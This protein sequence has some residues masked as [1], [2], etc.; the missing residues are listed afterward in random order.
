ML[1]RAAVI[2]HPVAH[3][4]SPVIHRKA[5]AELG[6]DWSYDAID[7]APGGV[8]DFVPGLDASWVGLSVTMPHKV[9]IARH[10]TP[11][12]LVTLTGVA[13]TWVPGV[14]GAI[15]RN[16]DVPG[17]VEACRVH[18]VPAPRR[19]AVVGNGATAR[20]AV[21]A[22]SRL[23]AREVVVLGRDAGRASSLGPLAEALG[24]GFRAHT[25]GSDPITVD[26]LVSTV[27]AG[28]LADHAQALAAAS[29]VVFDSVYDPWPTPLAQ[30][31][32]GA[33]RQVLNGL[34]LLA[35]QAIFQI[36]LMT[37]HRIDFEVLHA[38]ADAELR[39]REVMGD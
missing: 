32:E 39:S 23:G 38:A 31:A 10:G 29:T 24:L 6:L 8:D 22:A 19:V 1:R 25:L 30:A 34:D 26:L 27:P 11:D 16:T 2:G 35:A 3:S 5:Y 21:C 36:E 14:D 37:G 9:D 4:L 17:Y 28:A 18:D 12:E 7:V 33:G 15:V 13:N 20:S